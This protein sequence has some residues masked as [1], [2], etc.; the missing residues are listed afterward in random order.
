MF[1]VKSA[2]SSCTGF[3]SWGR[4]D[5]LDDFDFDP[6]PPQAARA[7]TAI[8]T[9]IERIMRPTVRRRR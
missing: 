1:V 8:A 7:S 2:G 3:V 5:A 6:P 4:L 9:A